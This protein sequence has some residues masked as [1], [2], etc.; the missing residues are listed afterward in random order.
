[1][2]ATRCKH[3]LAAYAGESTASTQPGPKT[4][5]VAT[6]GAAE[7]QIQLCS[8][9]TAGAWTCGLLKAGAR[10]QGGSL[11]TGCM[12]ICYYAGLDH[13]GQSNVGASGSCRCM[14]VAHHACTPW[15]V[16]TCSLHPFRRGVGCMSSKHMLGLIFTLS[17]LHACS[18]LHWFTSCLRRKER[19]WCGVS[20]GCR[21][22]NWA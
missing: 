12:Y 16:L 7:R 18:C 9:S 15:L 13:G 22:C 14:G 4:A 19:I 10:G 5:M 2:I 17:F 6:V 21:W 20:S 11:R 8:N 1:M 3:S